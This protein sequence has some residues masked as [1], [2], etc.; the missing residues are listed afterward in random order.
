MATTDHNPLTHG[1]IPVGLRGLTALG[2][3]SGLEA[4]IATGIF[5]RERST[6][7]GGS[8]RKV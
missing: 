3:V 5:I 7:I 8:S 1:L 6:G 4:A 2:E